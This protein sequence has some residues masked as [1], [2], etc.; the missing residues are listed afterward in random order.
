MSL[1]GADYLPSHI[2]VAAVAEVQLQTEGFLTR[3][4]PASNERP[5]QETYTQPHIN[6]SQIF[7]MLVKHSVLALDGQIVR[8]QEARVGQ[9]AP[10][11]DGWML[12]R[13]YCVYYT[14]QNQPA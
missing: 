5:R 8:S 13:V 10:L 3:G 11:C 7:V 9:K 4:A 2:D 6:S 12:Y 1:Y 14:V